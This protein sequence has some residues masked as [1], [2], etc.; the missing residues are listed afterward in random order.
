MGDPSP[1]SDNIPAIVF[2]I[3][4]AMFAALTPALA[5]GSAAERARL[6]PMIIFIFVWSTIV[7]DVLACWT[8]NPNGWSYQLGGL[9][10]YVLLTHH[11]NNIA[12]LFDYRKISKS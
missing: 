10:L 4:Q 8:W 9:D 7:Y 2:C 3:Y 6:L 5:I 12:L 11:S 1:G